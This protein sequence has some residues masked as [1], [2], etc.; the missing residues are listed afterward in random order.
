SVAHRRRGEQRGRRPHPLR[1]GGQVAP[2]PAKVLPLP[3]A[4]PQVALVRLA[5]EHAA[6]RRNVRQHDRD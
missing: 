4:R 2:R 5:Q 1:V 3:P 6:P